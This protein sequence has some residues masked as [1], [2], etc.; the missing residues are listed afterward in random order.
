MHYRKTSRA[1]V[2]CRNLHATT[3]VMLSKAQHL[4]F[5]AGE[6]EREPLGLNPHPNLLPQGEG[7]SLQCVIAKS[8]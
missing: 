3:D 1:R 5:C 7:T 8:L 6:G 2:R 4:V